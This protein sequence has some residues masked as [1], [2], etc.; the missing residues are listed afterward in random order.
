MPEK[1]LFASD[2]SDTWTKKVFWSSEISKY[3]GIDDW[4]E[5]PT[6]KLGEA[7]KKWANALTD[8]QEDTGRK[9]EWK[10]ITNTPETSGEHSA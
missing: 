8:Q 7:S 3:S 1:E 9:Y 2:L 10:K 6:W 4:S 5:K